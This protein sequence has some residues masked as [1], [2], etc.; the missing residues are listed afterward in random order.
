MPETWT[1]A[2]RRRSCLYCGASSALLLRLPD[3]R[4]VRACAPC[5]RGN[6]E[7]WSC[8]TERE[9]MYEETEYALE[10]DRHDVVSAG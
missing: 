6:L 5:L 2:N 3:G 7:E 9:P 1:S 10:V 4:N 8:G